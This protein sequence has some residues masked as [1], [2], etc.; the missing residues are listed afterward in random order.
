MSQSAIA[1]HRV[2]KIVL[3]CGTPLQDFDRR[4]IAPTEW[5]RSR[6]LTRAVDADGAMSRGL[7]EPCSRFAI[8]DVRKRTGIDENFVVSIP[9]HDTQRVGM[10]VAS[11]TRP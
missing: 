3:R 6:R 4:R 2:K 1:A 11:A 9:S 7:A 8:A 5:T 10:T